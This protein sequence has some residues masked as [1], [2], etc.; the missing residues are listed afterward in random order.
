MKLIYNYTIQSNSFASNTWDKHR[1]WLCESEQEYSNNLNDYLRR[2]KKIQEDFDEYPD[3]ICAQYKWLHNHFEEQRQIEASEY[4][5]G[6]EW[7]GKH[8]TAHG[9]SWTEQRDGNTTTDYYLRPS[10]V[11]NEGVAERVGKFNGYGS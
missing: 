10:S 7:C 6:H 11:I 3:D 4:Y 2:A 5:K 9:F 1:Y 8:F